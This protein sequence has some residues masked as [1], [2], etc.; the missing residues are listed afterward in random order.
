MASINDPSIALL[1]I[2]FAGAS[3]DP[4]QA[5]NEFAQNLARTRE[6]REF[7]ATLAGNNQLRA[8]LAQRLA[9]QEGESGRFSDI[10]SNLPAFIDMLGRQGAAGF[11]GAQPTGFSSAADLT[12]IGGRQGTIASDL[13]TA[14]NQA[15]QGGQAFAIDPA[16]QGVAGLTSTSTDPTAVQAKKAEGVKLK[17]P[18]PGT[19]ATAETTVSR[20]DPAILRGMAPLGGGGGS[21]IASAMQAA[22]SP[23]FEGANEAVEVSPANTEPQVNAV[24]RTI[25]D[26]RGSN[27]FSGRKI[28]VKTGPNNTLIVVVDD[29]TVIR[30]VDTQG[31]TVNE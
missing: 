11:I 3:G 13:G 1:N 16:L 27:A 19:G 24:N 10:A 23:Q 26:L 15:L 2:P 12:D 29:T 4:F 9:T 21:P 18:I 6:Q 17:F 5:P 31:K 7:L 14:V 22:R 8:V 25:A 28:S 20:N 30:I